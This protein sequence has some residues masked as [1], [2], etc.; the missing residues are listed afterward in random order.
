MAGWS[1][2]WGGGGRG[3]WKDPRVDQGSVMREYKKVGGGMGVG[4]SIR[5]IR[6]PRW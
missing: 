2:F 3:G 4:G 6:S 1:F 5:I